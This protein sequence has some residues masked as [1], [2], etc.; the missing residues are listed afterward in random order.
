MKKLKIPKDF[1][2][3]NVMQQTA[4]HQDKDGVFQSLDKELKNNDVFYK[5]DIVDGKVRQLSI[6]VGEL[7]Q[8]IE[9][10]N[11]VL[12]GVTNGWYEET[13]KKPQN[14]KQDREEQ[15]IE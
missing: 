10:H 9:T 2:L 13:N 1:V 12:K 6:T 11:Q 4:W 7:K 5:T 14:T 8:I 15:V 3:K